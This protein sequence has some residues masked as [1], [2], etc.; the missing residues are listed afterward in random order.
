MSTFGEAKVTTK[1]AKNQIF[2]GFIP[3]LFA[4]KLDYNFV[5]PPNLYTFASTGKVITLSSSTFLSPLST[6][7]MDWLISF[8]K[9]NF[10]LINLAVGA[11]GVIVAIIALMV[12]IK[13]RKRKKAKAKEQEQAKAKEQ[14]QAKAKEQEKKKEEEG[15]NAEKGK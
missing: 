13:A 10:D 5:L 11:I 15:R 1:R 3:Y 2:I 12:E 7:N 14:E 4:K 6:K 9:E 8:A